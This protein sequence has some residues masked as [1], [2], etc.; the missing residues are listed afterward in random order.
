M[1]VLNERIRT[2]QFDWKDEEKA[3]FKEVKDAYKEDQIL[4]L[5]DE[6]KQ[7]WVHADASDYAIGSVIS[8]IDDQG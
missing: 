2:K 1:R 6:E 7:I 5:F 8:Q 4:M 3:A